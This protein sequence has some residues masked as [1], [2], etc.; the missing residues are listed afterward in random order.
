MKIASANLQMAS[1]HMATQEHQVQES[2]KMWVGPRRPGFAGEPQNP[3]RAA[4]PPVVISPAARQAQQLESETAN[5]VQSQESEV[6]NDPKLVLIRSVIEMLTGR[7]VRLFNPEELQVEGEETAQANPENANRPAGFGVEYERHESYS[8][9]ESTTFA[10]RGLIKTGDGREI[11]FQ[12]EMTMSRSYAETSDI[13][14]RLGDA[15]VKDPLVLNFSGQAA[16][17]TDTRFE[18][19][20]DADGQKDSINF[21]KSGSGFLVFDRNGD[22]AINNGREMFGALTGDGFKELAALDDDRNGWID[23]NDSAYRDLQ[24]WR[25]NSQGQDDLST[26]QEANVGAISLAR[27]ATPFAVKDTNNQL[28]GQIQNTGIF[29]QET[30]EAGT[31]QKIDLAV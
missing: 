31:I 18:F 19:D 12:L 10:A 23:E 27:V 25:K 21:V 11:A 14:L 6:E 1:S 9:T 30:G 20:L 4:L 16:Q 22:G 13:S 28:Q 29:L 2:V 3:P 7:K 8:E 5:A 26:L 24:V 15:V 17:L